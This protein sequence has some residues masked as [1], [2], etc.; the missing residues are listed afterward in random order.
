MKKIIKNPR[1]IIAVI[2]SSS[3]GPFLGGLFGA[4]LSASIDNIESAIHNIPTLFMKS[5]GMLMMGP[6]IALPTIIL[7]GIPVYFLLQKYNSQFSWLYMLFGAFGGFGMY[8]S[9]S[10]FR[11]YSLYL[12]DAIM[13][14]SLGSFTAL[15]FWFITIFLPLKR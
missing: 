11:H 2:I 7:F 6:V 13:Y 10:L 15:V 3:L 1:I 8:I 12:E 9:V 4:L 5:L 14:T